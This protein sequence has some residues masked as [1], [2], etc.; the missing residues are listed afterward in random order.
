MLVMLG[1]VV[2][3][4]VSFI[5]PTANL[6]VTAWNP[7]PAL[8]IF[9]FGQSTSFVFSYSAGLSLSDWLIRGND[10]LG[11]QSM[12]LTLI[13]AICYLAARAAIARYA[14][15]F[16][17]FNNFK[18]STSNIKSGKLSVL[19]CNFNKAVVCLRA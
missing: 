16:D 3:D 13:N 19:W 18:N 10:P 12:T 6:N 8:A 1:V 15:G 11:M 4:W 9:A 7:L 17:S 14:V 5:Q 2:L